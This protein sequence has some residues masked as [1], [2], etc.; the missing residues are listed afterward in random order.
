MKVEA[1]LLQEADDR[2]GRDGFLLL[3]RAIMAAPSLGFLATDQKWRKLSSR[4]NSIIL[5]GKTTVAIALFSAVHT[6]NSSK[7]LPDRLI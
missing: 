1:S 3:G 2:T 7:K 5:S 6:L 4:W